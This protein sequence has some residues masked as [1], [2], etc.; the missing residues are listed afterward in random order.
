[1]EELGLEQG[2]GGGG[3]GVGKRGVLEAAMAAAAIATYS[4]LLLMGSE[5]GFNFDPL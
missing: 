3:S 4:S 2:G 5:S 1:M